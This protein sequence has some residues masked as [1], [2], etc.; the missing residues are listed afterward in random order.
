MA[1]IVAEARDPALAAIK[2]VWWRDALAALDARSP[3][4]EPLLAAAAAHLVPTLTGAALGDAE[5]AWRALL[6]D[7]PFSDELL[8]LHAE[9]R[10]GKLFA[11]AARLAGVAPE[12]WL[13]A[14]GEAWA[15]AELAQAARGEVGTRSTLLAA[16]RRASVGTRRW[17][18]ALR[19]LGALYHASAGGERAPVRRL[20]RLLLHRYSGL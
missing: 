1:R 11:S 19:G 7:P 17:P 14:A 15:L 3:P 5:P 18:R 10:G 2:L 13:H 9:G 16:E 4:A 12:P 20:G 8:G 6:S